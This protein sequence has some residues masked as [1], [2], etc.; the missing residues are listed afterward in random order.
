MTW[1]VATPASATKVEPPI[2]R[3]DDILN[4]IGSKVESPK[5]VDNA[6]YHAE[7]TRN[8][9]T[10]WNRILKVS[11][12]TQLDIQITHDRTY[13]LV[14]EE[15]AVRV[16]YQNKGGVNDTMNIF[17]EDGQLTTSSSKIPILIYGTEE[18]K[19]RLRPYQIQSSNKGSRLEVRNMKG[20][21]LT[22]IEWD[23]ENVRLGQRIDVGL[24][25]S[26]LA[27]KL[28]TNK[29]HG[30]NSISVGLP[31]A[32]PRGGIS[33]SYKGADVARHSMTF[34]SQNFYSVSIP[35]ALRYMARHDNYAIFNDKFGNLIYAPE[36]FHVTDR[37][38]GKSKGS[39]N[40]KISPIADIANRIIVSGRSYALND[41]IE[42]TVDD[43]ESQKRT[44]S[45]RTER[46]N[47]PMSTTHTSARRT[48]SQLLRLNKKAQGAIKSREHAQSWD[49]GPGDVV[50][51]ENPIDKSVSRQAVI[52]V[53]H[54]MRQGETN[55]QFVSYEKGIEGILNAFDDV[56]NLQADSQAMD[57]STQIQTV[58]KSM[59]D[60]GEIKVR[61]FAK[62]RS[63]IA[64][65][66]RQYSNRSTDTHISLA[67]SNNGNDIHS[68]FILG[69]RAKNIGDAPARGA[70]G[71]GGAR[72]YTGSITSTTFTLAATH[73]VSSVAQSI[74]DFPASGHLIVNEVQHVTF[75]GKAGN[76][77]TGLAVTAPNGASLVTGAVS[78]RLLRPPA[79]EMGT[80]KGV[81]RRM[82]L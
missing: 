48:A 12:P 46:V 2:G 61:G 8:I 59:T 43:A 30:L 25:T 49:I 24:R 15:S 18:Q 50:S 56:G 26:D 82:R 39:G 77:L 11:P 73:S 19:N 69:H 10:T 60:A 7:Y 37:K 29:L 3:L 80:H 41:D 28:F 57:N 13:R 22:D 35:S 45:I 6:V 16:A 20:R 76:T 34:L 58:D 81:E 38:I 31:F 23:D 14:E 42:I 55:F 51:Y 54:N 53:E 17:Y 9:D 4:T 74:D 70:I 67:A 72:H 64:S 75:T 66:A 33:A 21:S 5:F 68:G 36:I 78:I 40:A 62:V 32:G 27:Q 52:E 44:G 47:D 71:L 65:R 63:V 1:T 79:H